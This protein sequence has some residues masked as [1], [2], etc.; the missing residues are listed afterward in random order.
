MQLPFVEQIGDPGLA[1]GIAKQ[2]N[3]IRV[4]AASKT[5]GQ[6]GARIN[7]IS[8]GIIS[9]PMSQHELASPLGEGMRA[10][11]ASSASGRMGTPEDIAAATAFLLSHDS[12]FITG[13]DLLVDGGVTAALRTS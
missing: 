13:T 5:W 1:Y 7:S 4:R 8:P 6:R 2:G 3:H 12:D 11:I 9:T 10:M